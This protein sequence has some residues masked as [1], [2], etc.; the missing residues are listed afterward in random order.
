[1]TVPV[2]DRGARDRRAPRLGAAWARSSERPLELARARADRRSP[3]SAAGLVLA[4]ILAGS[5]ARPVE[6]L[7]AA[8]GRLGR[9]DLDARVEPEGPR[10]IDELGRSFNRMAGELSSN[11]A[12]QRD[13]VA[14]ASHQLRTPLTGIKLRLEAIRAEGGAAAERGDEG[15]GRARPAER[16]RRRP[17]RARA[18][19]RP[20]RRARRERRPGRGRRGPRAGAGP[21]RPPS[22][23]HELRVADGAGGR[24]W[25]A[26]GGRRPHPRQPDRERDP[27]LAARLAG[28]RRGS[29]ATATARARRLRHGPRHPAGGARARLRALLPR[30]RRAAIGPGHGP[31]ARDRGR[32]RR[33]LE[34]TGR[35]PRRPGHARAGQLPGA[36]YRLLTHA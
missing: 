16:A 26:P 34:R 17:A 6:K 5:I 31:R 4:W 21:S 32:A 35:A 33:A 8:A 29:K 36:G 27:L 15:R 1:M 2:T 12:A 24:A 14:N 9:G 25:A 30:R 20:T 7:R 18:G 19:G 11:L 10:E 13:F 23:G 28:R 22:A 3:S